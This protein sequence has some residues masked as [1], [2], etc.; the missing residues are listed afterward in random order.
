SAG[1]IE[2]PPAAC[3]SVATAVPDRPD[4]PPSRLGAHVHI[5]EFGRFGLRGTGA[6]PVP[7]RILVFDFDHVRRGA[8]RAS[9]AA[10]TPCC[11]VVPR[12][13][14][15]L[16]SAQIRAPGAFRFQPSNSSASGGCIGS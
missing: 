10:P 4:A 14:E 5:G 8:G 15:S 16:Y 6:A 3:R 11:Q 12:S 9:V 1:T 2:R 7:D 13:E